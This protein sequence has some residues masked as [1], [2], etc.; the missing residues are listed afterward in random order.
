MEAGVGTDDTVRLVVP[1]KLRH[2]SK[3]VITL[4][5]SRKGCRMDKFEAVK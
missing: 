5:G 1:I 3:I 2:S 4:V